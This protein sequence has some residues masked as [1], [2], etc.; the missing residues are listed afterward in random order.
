MINTKEQ[1]I[2]QGRVVRRICEGKEVEMLINVAKERL[3]DEK[4]TFK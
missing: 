1:K 4:V 3:I 2:K